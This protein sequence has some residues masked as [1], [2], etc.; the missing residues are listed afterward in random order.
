MPTQTMTSAGPNIR[1]KLPG[2]NAQK[3]LKGDAQYI[4]PSYTRSYPL[5]AKKGHGSIIEDV[6][7]NE[8]L[9]FSSGIAVCSTGHCHPEVVAAIQKQAAELIHMSGTDFYYENMVTLGE[10]LA[11]T[12]PMSGPVRVYYGNSGTEAIEAAMKLARYHTKRQGIIAFYGAFHGRTMGALSLTASKVQQRRRFF[13]VVPGVVHAPFP[14][15]YRRPEGMNEAQFIKECVA[16]IEDKIFKTIMP[17]EECAAIFIEPVQG[18]GGYVPVPTEYMQ[19][20]RRIC[21]KHGILL[22]ADEVQSGAG[23]TGKMWAI[24]HTGVEP[25]IITMAKG[26]A[27]GMPLGVTMSRA[28]I[29]DWVPGSHAST[30]GGNP[31]CIE[32]ALA[33]LNVLEREAIANAETVGNHILRRISKWTEK[34]PMVGDVRGRGLM[35]GV[36]IVKDQKTRAT[37]HDERDRIVDLAFERGALYLGAGENSIR[38]APPLIL[39]AEQADMGLDILEE[40]I[41]IVEKENQK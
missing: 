13:P 15:S 19:E 35:I 12:A 22:V 39:T 6:D 14:Y 10:R 26:I 4:S 34:H 36:E 28:E 21:D 1:T 18:E 30:F 11:K 29:M 31:I 5:V 38:I 24:E 25:D 17:P 27:S 16:F 7:G 37:A 32:A 3:I 9:D 40:C 41:S 33:T 2:P 8:F 23:R 20:L